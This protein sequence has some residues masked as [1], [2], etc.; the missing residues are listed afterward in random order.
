MVKIFSLT[1]LTDR[2]IHSIIG[3]DPSWLF[4]K[5]WDSYPV[6]SPISAY[7]PVEPV[8]GVQYLAAQEPWVST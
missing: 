1:Y 2:F 4:R 5:E 6:L 3:E 8:A 7:A